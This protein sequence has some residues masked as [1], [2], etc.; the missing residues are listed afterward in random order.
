MVTFRYGLQAHQSNINAVKFSP[1]GRYLATGSDDKMIIIWEI[2]ENFVT[3]CSKEKMKKWS[4]KYQ[5]SGHMAEVLDLK[6][7]ANSKYLISAGV[8]KRII[9]WQVEK[10]R[11]E[12]ILEEHSRFVQGVAVDPKFKYI[13]SESND[14]TVKIWKNAKTKKN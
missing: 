14:R 2:R 4:C 6:W 13:I 5:L 1:D 9:V 11:Y 3:T 10:S 12:R 8:D 7:S